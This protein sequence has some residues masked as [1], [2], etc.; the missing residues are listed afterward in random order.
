MEIPVV[1]ECEKI[2]HGRTDGAAVNPTPQSTTKTNVK[3]EDTK[4][5]TNI[6]GVENDVTESRNT[7]DQWETNTKII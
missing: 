3:M 4:G 1:K 6:P 5:S 7:P 2:V